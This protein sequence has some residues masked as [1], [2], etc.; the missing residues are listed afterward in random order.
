[1]RISEIGAVG[2]E[3]NTPGVAGPAA[4]A[5]GAG[6]VI[7]L[8]VSAAMKVQSEAVDGS[9]QSTV[10]DIAEELVQRGVN[11]YKS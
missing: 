9:M 2:I 3:K 7:G 4:G 5:V 1:M 6:M 8:V 11:Y 10:D